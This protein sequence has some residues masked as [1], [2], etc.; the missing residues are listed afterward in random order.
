MVVSGDVVDRSV[1]GT[2]II[3]YN[4][5][6]LSGNEA[7]TVFRTVTILDTL[8]PVITLSVSNAAGDIATLVAE[9]YTWFAEAL[10]DGAVAEASDVT[11]N[12][13][14]LFDGIDAS[15]AV[16]SVALY[17]DDADAVIDG[18]SLFGGRV[19]V[20]EQFALN[21]GNTTLLAA[22][23]L[24]LTL[25]ELTYRPNLNESV[26]LGTLGLFVDTG[27]L[28]PDQSG[29]SF[30][31]TL[32]YVGGEV[33]LDSGAASLSVLGSEIRFGTAVVVT[34]IGG[35][36]TIDPNNTATDA[37]LFSLQQGSIRFPDYPDLP[38]VDLS[39]LTVRR[40]GVSLDNFTAD[41][42]AGPDDPV[43]SEAVSASLQS[44]GADAAMATSDFSVANVDDV[45]IEVP[46]PQVISDNQV[47]F[48][49]HKQTAVR[50]NAEADVF[51]DN[52]P[53]VTLWVTLGTISLASTADVTILEGVNG[54]N[55]ITFRGDSES[56]H[57][58]MDGMVYTADNANSNPAVLT[59]TVGNYGGG[60]A[61]G[62]VDVSATVVLAFP[63]DRPL[64]V[65]PGIVGTF[66]KAN[67]ADDEPAY[68]TW[69]L[70]RGVHPHTMEPEQLSRVND[71]LVA[72]L[73]TVGYTLGTDLFTVN[74]DWRVLPGPKDGEIDGVIDL[75][76]GYHCRS[77]GR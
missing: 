47:V 9:S 6:D 77:A 60:A 25:D 38:T 66:P 59:I 5:E 28:L 75:G 52:E 17:D 1:P 46:G 33:D 16:E 73:Q 72:S 37:E 4:C 10:P 23:G 68:Q 74:Y 24:T 55:T 22:A 69:L 30:G 26:S 40:D 62:V 58:A 7:Q 12:L 67:D 14:G 11:L 42:S 48:S 15:A 41:F 63:P 39:G 44:F 29:D 51:I 35:T 45:Q 65:V 61:G 19:R 36:L 27:A 64:L 8:P 21:A 2:Y 70:Q 43:T 53:E 31:A 49:E 34:G 56:V 13:L 20:D 32:Q 76:E 71:D 54:T 57:A 50:I 18:F 3:H